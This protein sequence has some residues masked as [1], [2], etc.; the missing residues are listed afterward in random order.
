MVFLVV[1]DGKKY[2]I[3]YYKMR[4][5]VAR[6]YILLKNGAY[7]PVQLLLLITVL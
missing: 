6:F 4:Q 1:N 5:N 2:E 7:I 3:L